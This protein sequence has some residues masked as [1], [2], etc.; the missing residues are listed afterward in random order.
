MR[1]DETLW[2]TDMLARPM[3]KS[4]DDSTA[5]T[6]NHFHGTLNGGNASSKVIISFQSNKK[7]VAS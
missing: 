5:F 4:L 1:S 6:D 7:N 2:E 3:V